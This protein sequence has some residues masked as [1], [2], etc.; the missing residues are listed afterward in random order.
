[1]SVDIKHDDHFPSRRIPSKGNRMRLI[2]SSRDNLKFSLIYI[3]IKLLFLLLYLCIPVTTFYYELNRQ[4]ETRICIPSNCIGAAPNE[5]C[6]GQSISCICAK[7][8]GYY[9]PED[10]PSTPIPADTP[11]HSPLNTKAAGATAKTI[12]LNRGNIYRY[13][14]AKS[15][16]YAA[17]EY[18]QALICLLY[19]TTKSY[20]R[21]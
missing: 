16:M 21:D 20:I 15:R 1:M 6:T 2:L 8:F 17:L 14:M 13:I 10:V 5:R 18:K 9:I 7:P 3:S 11:A 12:I 4:R 19:D